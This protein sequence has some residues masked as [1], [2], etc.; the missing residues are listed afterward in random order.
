M[1]QVTFLISL[2]FF[3]LT[4]LAQTKSNT[5]FSKDYYLKKSKNARTTAHVLLIRGSGLMLGGFVI[6]AR[7]VFGTEGDIGGAFVLAGIVSDLVS[8]PFYSK[9]HKNAKIAASLVFTRQR[10]AE[11]YNRI[12]FVNHPA[13][14]INL[15]F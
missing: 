3:T 1:K 5:A 4:A 14:K 7:D 10:V 13:I 8:F 11:Q 9:A 12:S 15:N 2:L 6:G